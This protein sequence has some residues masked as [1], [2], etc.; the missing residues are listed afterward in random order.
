MDQNQLDDLIVQ[1]AEHATTRNLETIISTLK[2]AK[3]GVSPETAEK[4]EVIW[5]SWNDENDEIELEPEQCAFVIETAALGFAN[6]PIFRKVLIAAIRATLPPYLNRVAVVRALGLRDDALPPN[7]IIRR[8]RKLLALKTGCYVFRSA[9]WGTAGAPDSESGTI[10]IT[11]C[12]GRGSSVAIPL[13]SI[14]KEASLLGPGLE[15][16]RIIDPVKAARMDAATFRAAVKKK[17]L[18]P[19]SENQ[20]KAMAQLTAAAGKSPDEFNAWWSSETP[21]Q[22]ARPADPRTSSN[23]RSLE[24]IEVLIDREAAAGQATI[25]TAGDIASLTAFFT[26]LRPD[27]A[28]R[29]ALQLAKVIAKVAPRTAPD[30]LVP[31]LTPLLAKAPFWPEKPE[32]APLDQLAVW[33]HIP[34]KDLGVMASVTIAV[35]NI[36]YLIRCAMRLPL[37]ALNAVCAEIEPAAL[38]RALAAAAVSGSDMLL[39]IWKNRKKIQLSPEVIRQVNVINVVK[40]LSQEK[41]PREWGAAQRELKLHLLEKNDFHQQMVAAAGDDPASITGALQSALFLNPGERQSLLVKLARHSESL[42]DHIENGA[43]QQ[44]LNAGLSKREKVIAAPEVAEPNY[45][46]IKSHQRLLAELNDLINVQIPENREALKVARAHGD[47]RENAEFDAA[48]ERRNFLGRRRSELEKDL[49]NLQPVSLRIAD[50]EGVVQI[51]TVVTLTDAAGQ[52]TVYT[53]LGAWD[54]DPERNFVSYRTRLGQAVYRRAVGEQVTLPN[55]SECT[56][57]KVT[58]LPEELLQELE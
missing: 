39:W 25:Y 9:G 44:I 33:G 31:L 23:G 51:G 2:N 8:F 14:L 52:E 1:V 38:D 12:N 50:P 15:T 11:A 37:K 43:G 26:R 55:G 24:E 36:D 21:A 56:I 42:R 13:E 7:E 28:V 27:T 6:S 46:S 30:D 57:T 22:A 48:K 41:L 19:V 29:E 4:L 10:A 17:A 18:C 16:S 53:I 54:G 5:S 58:V 40:A 49:A 47:F 34:A 32:T 35:F 20:M 3:G 45:T